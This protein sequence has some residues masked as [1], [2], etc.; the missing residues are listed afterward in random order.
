MIKKVMNIYFAKR[1]IAARLKMGYSQR[2]ACAKWGVPKRTLWN[3]EIGRHQPGPKYHTQ[4]E[5]VLREIEAMPESNYGP[6]KKISPKEKKAGMQ[7]WIDYCR[8]TKIHNLY[9]IAIGIRDK[10]A[11]SIPGSPPDTRPSYP[12]PFANEP[13]ERLKGF[14]KPL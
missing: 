9:Q 10:R 4:M 11:V 14:I 5:K 6:Q 3:W 13:S 8:Q 7:R 1:L 2:R 12:E